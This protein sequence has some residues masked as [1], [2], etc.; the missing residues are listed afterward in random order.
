[1]KFTKPAISVT[2]QIALLH[3]RGMIIDDEPTA[4]HYLCHISYYRLRAYWLPFEAPAPAAGDH[5]FKPGTN[6]TDVLALY[7][8]DRQLRLL[9]LDAI[10][11]V[12]VAVRA[13]W[14]HH[15]AMAFGP[16]GYLDQ[17][18]HDDPVKHAESV[19][20][21]TKEIRRSKDTFVKHYNS[22]YDDPALPPTWMVAEVMSFGALSKWIDN[23]RHRP[24]R[25]AIA[26]PFSLDERVFTSFAHHV[27]IIRNIAAHHGRLW[28]KRFAFKMILPRSPGQLPLAMRGA[29]ER[30]LHNTLVML[31]HLLSV[32]APGNEWRRRV[33]ELITGCPQAN[34]ALMGFPSDWQTR[35]AWRVA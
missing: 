23:L 19:A 2:D 18:H 35:A 17:A 22:T 31:D 34:P 26:K 21:L 25:Q 3:R 30:L 28:N 11:R 13:S 15:M 12:E 10:E 27:S 29:D 5:A 14:A 8:F 7:V 33:V 32:V 9:V 16:H 4:R 1:M 24:D 6:F 20:D